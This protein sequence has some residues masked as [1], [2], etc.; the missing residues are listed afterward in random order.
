ME[1]SEIVIGS[2]DTENWDVIE[3]SEP[4][5]LW[6]HLNSFPSPHVVIRSHEPTEFEIMEAAYL[7]KARSRYRNI[8]NIKV[9]YTR[10]HN[11]Q[12]AKTVG[13]VDIVSKRRCRYIIPV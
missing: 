11:L 12:L 10:V 7:C 6:F 3:K 4:G 5:H 1:P 8:R 2:N 9:V 13:S